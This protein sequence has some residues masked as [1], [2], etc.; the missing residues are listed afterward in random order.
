MAVFELARLTICKPFPDVEG[1]TATESITASAPVWFG[2]NAPPMGSNAVDETP[3]ATRIGASAE[4]RVAT[5]VV[6]AD[7]VT[8]ERPPLCVRA[9]GL[10]LD[11]SRAATAV[12]SG[13]TFV[14]T[15]APLLVVALATTEYSI[16]ETPD[17][18]EAVMT[19]GAVSPLIETL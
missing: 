15:G 19:N 1:V 6:T 9:N 16:P 12:V 8:T 11:V 14:V 10:P 4:L 2:V 3:F 13:V 18:S 7:E 5:A 17:G